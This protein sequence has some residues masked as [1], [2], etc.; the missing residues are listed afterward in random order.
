MCVSETTAEIIR[1]SNPKKTTGCD[2]ISMSLM[3]ESKEAV[4][5]VMTYMINPIIRTSI[6][7]ESQN[8]A[9]VKQL[10]KKGE[11]TTIN[12][13]RPISSLTT[14]SKNVKIVLAV[15]ICSI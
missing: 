15:Q 9:R 1:N 4:A 14:L 7:P 8:I 3:K 5:P 11:K 6:L 12:D 10:Y 2:G 13:H